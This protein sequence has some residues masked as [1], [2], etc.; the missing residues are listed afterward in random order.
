MGS[1]NAHDTQI[2]G[3]DAGMERGA[4]RPAHHMTPHFFQTVVHQF[5]NPRPICSLLAPQIV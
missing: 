3:A 1:G 4:G 5:M 2:I